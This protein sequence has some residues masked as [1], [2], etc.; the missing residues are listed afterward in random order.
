MTLTSAVPELWLVPTNLTT[1]LQEWFVVPGFV[2][3]M[4]NM[5]TKFKV[6]ICTNNKDMK[7]DTKCRNWGGLG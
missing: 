4:I 2:L 7:D 5:S 6:F 3:T 1:P